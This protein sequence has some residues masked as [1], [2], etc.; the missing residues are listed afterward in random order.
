MADERN[1][2]GLCGLP[3][4]TDMIRCLVPEASQGIK[5]EARN[6]A[7]SPFVLLA[8]LII[9]LRTALPADG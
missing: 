7:A 4:L 6:E 2:A 8:P 9:L 1:Q 5:R 3:W